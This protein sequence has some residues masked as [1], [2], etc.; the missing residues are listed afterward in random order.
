WE[1]VPATDDDANHPDP[2]WASQLGAITAPT[3]VLSGGPA[4]FLPE[5]NVR[6]LAELIPGG[7]AVT[8]PVGHLI[9]RSD[10]EGFLAELKGF[11]IY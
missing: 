10:P 6:R 1:V 9:H 11:G 4:S 7:R 2:L 3:L 5:A 8:I